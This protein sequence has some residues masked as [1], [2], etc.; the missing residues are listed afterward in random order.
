MRLKTIL[1]TSDQAAMAF[2]ACVIWY[3]LN[4]VKVA[5]SLG[6]VVGAVARKA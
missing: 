4:W 3:A 6:I 1:A 2:S 5:V